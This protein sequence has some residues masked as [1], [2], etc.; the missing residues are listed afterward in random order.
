MLHP[1]PLFSLRSRT[2][3]LAAFAGLAA[4]ALAGEKHLLL[5]ATLIAS[6]RNLATELGTAEKSRNNPLFAE[7]HPWEPRFDNLYPNVIWDRDDH[8]YKCWYTPFVVS[9]LDEQ[10]TTAA[11]AYWT[12]R[13]PGLCYATSS[14]GLRWE[15]PL[16]PQFPFAGQPSNVVRPHAGDGGVF[17]DE[18]EADPRRRYKFIFRPDR[19]GVLGGLAVAFSPDGLHWSKP[20][21]LHFPLKA[22][23]HNNAIWAPTLGRYVALTRDW[24][25]GRKNPAQR[26][27]LVARTESSDFIH[28]SPPQI[29]LRGPEDTRQLYSMPIFFYGGLYLGLPAIFNTLTDR[30]DTGL[31]WSKDTLAWH[32]VS[33]GR[34]LIGNASAEHA[35]DWGCVYASVPV[36]SDN[37]VKI[38][39]GASDGPHTG[40]R[41]GYFA[42][43]T[44][45]PDGFAGV[46][47]ADPGAAAE[48]TT[49]AL[50]GGGHPT[51][52]VTADIAAGGSIEAVLM[53]AADGAEM[54]RATIAGERRLNAEPLSLGNAP[55]ATRIQIKF[56]LRQAKLYSFEF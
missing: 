4:A 31:A 35:Y 1:R 14:D 12:Y 2:A 47:P 34:P 18:H 6:A 46:V 27:R 15:K 3:H 32:L 5:D 37:D 9:H 29:V 25:A 22:D 48:L 19:A 52:A 54:G 24:G 44:L 40:L 17:K 51:L 49:I 20:T 50:T 8:L 55:A 21:D 23:T 16:L 41:K 56:I 26:V 43:A 38:Y 28:W 36:F 11:H 7:Q 45:R 39:Y 33:S 30:T 53:N 13:E 10:R 42:L